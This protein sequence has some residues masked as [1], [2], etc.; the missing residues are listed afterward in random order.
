MW[1][2]NYLW[3][4]IVLAK[5]W[6]LCAPN[7]EFA[8]NWNANKVIECTRFHRV[9][10]SI[11]ASCQFANQLCD[12]I[13]CQSHTQCAKCCPRSVILRHFTSIKCICNKIAFKLNRTE[14]VICKERKRERWN[15]NDYFLMSK[16]VHATH[17]LQC[18]Q[19]VRPAKVRS[20]ERQI[21]CLDHLGDRV[22]YVDGFEL[23]VYSAKK[24]LCA[25]K[26]CKIIKCFSH[27][28]KW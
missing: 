7:R 16:I 6:K 20:T 26:T 5:R 1:P 11:S 18:V 10:S 27:K 22:I 15:K 24:T 4:G 13:C 17:K 9:A 19:P 28:V 14:E 2:G 25:Y 23:L 8:P 21:V 3:I 12:N